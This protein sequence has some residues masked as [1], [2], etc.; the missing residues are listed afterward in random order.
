MN[1][2]QFTFE[3]YPWFT[4][5]LQ[6]P[7]VISKEPGVISINDDVKSAIVKIE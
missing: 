3:N 2:G 4:G 1:Q 6:E 5:F 7:G